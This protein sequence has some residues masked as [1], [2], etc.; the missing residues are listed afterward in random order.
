M[1]KPISLNREYCGCEMIPPI[2]EE[3]DYQYQVALQ[4][5]SED[6]FK[7][8]CNISSSISEDADYI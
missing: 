8:I 3:I 1:W 4:H 2:N 7:R 5:W 6:L